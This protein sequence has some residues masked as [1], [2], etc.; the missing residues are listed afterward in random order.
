M[1]NEELREE[2]NLICVNDLDDE[3]KKELMKS[4]FAH[5]SICRCT[6]CIQK[7]KTVAE[8]GLTMKFPEIYRET[9]IL[10]FKCKERSGIDCAGR[11]PDESTLCVVCFEKSMVR[12]KLEEELHMKKIQSQSQ[13][14]QSSTDGSSGGTV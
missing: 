7:A 12:E 9:G 3:T 10:C 6:Q 4:G 11:R 1:T 5:H 13:S 14:S 2:M 8:K